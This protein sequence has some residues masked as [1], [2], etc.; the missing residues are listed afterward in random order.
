MSIMFIGCNRWTTLVPLQRKVG[1]EAVHMQGQE[2]LGGSLSLPLNFSVNPKLQR[3]KKEKKKK[4]KK[5]DELRFV[6][7]VLALRDS[8]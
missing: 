8:A 5:E 1:R 3:K 7:L 4:K 2:V 6:L